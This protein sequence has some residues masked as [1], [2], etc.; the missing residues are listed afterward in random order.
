MAGG[1]RKEP[2]I[3]QA[4][5]LTIYCWNLSGGSGASTARDQQKWAP[6]LRPIARYFEQRMILSANRYPLRRIMRA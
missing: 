5:G 3:N 1:A 2:R 4:L 6:V